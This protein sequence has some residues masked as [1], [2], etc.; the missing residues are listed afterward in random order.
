MFFGDV[1]FVYSPIYGKAAVLG[2]KIVNFDV[3]GKFGMGI[4]QTKDDGTISGILEG[5][6]N[7]CP[8][9]GSLNNGSET[10]MF[11]Q[12]QIEWHPTTTFGGGIRVIFSD[13][14]A[15]RLEGRSIT[16]IETVN[17]TMLE[18]KNNFLVQGSVSVFVPNIKN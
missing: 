2:R 16:Y 15:A 5:E 9:L 3:Y 12:T 13:N 10:A 7:Q 4:G 18:M 17:S 6:D 11:C 14:L 1:T 8:E